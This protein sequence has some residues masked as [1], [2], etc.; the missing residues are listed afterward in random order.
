MQIAQVVEEA[1][2]SLASTRELLRAGMTERGIRSEV[3][4]GS[5]VRLRQGYFVRSA[6]W[7]GADYRQRH[8]V[9]ALAAREAAAGTIVFSHR[10]AATLLGLPVWSAWLNRLFP[11][12]ARE[13][14]VTTAFSPFKERQSSLDGDAPKDRTPSGAPDPRLVHTTAASNRR[15]SSHPFMFRHRGELSDS[16]VISSLGFTLTSGERTLFD[17]GRSEPFAIALACT[18]EF[19]RHQI[20]VN[21]SIDEQS[22]DEWQQRL[23]DRAKRFPHSRGMPAVRALATLAHPGADSPLETVSRL[24]CLQVGLNVKVQ[25]R[26]RSEW[27]GYN[28]LDF[29]F[30]GLGVFGECDGKAKYTD[31]K[32]LGKRSAD[33]VVHDEKRR[34]DWVVGTTGMR[35][36]RWGAADVETTEVFAQRLREFRLP[37]PGVPVRSYGEEIAL[38][39][40]KLR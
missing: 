20:T 28:Y 21:R 15:A 18:D 10:T 34:H 1:A 40:G 4:N 22:W 32:L 6:F 16:E 5:L 39:L 26:V 24:R 7:N 12:E 2:R 31:S 19:L 3:S 27:G 29:L 13:P 36:V 23:R 17:L 35:G 14:G 9:S 25:F 11:S 8:V 38:F 33:E 30:E 37:V